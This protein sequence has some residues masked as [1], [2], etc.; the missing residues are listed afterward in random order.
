MGAAIFHFTFLF[1]NGLK[2]QYMK[3]TSYHPGKP[4]TLEKFSFPNSAIRLY[5]Y[6][7]LL[8]E[9]MS[10]NRRFSGNWVSI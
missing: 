9:H 3:T 5:C 4:P 10:W 6:S 1:E 2:F 8:I 7:V